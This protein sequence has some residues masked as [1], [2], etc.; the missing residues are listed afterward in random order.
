MRAF[1]K[2]F[3]RVSPKEIFQMVNVNPA[4]ALRCENALGKIRPGF[5]A[6]LIA[7]PRSGSTDIFEQIIAV[8]GPVN[9]VMVNGECE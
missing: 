2:N 5:G 1:Q 3:P 9:F 4:C 7:I 8:N 6:D